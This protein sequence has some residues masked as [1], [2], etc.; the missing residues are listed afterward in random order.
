MPSRTYQLP[1]KNPLLSYWQDQES[2]AFTL[3]TI[4]IDTYGTEGLSWAPETIEMEIETDFGAD[5]PYDNYEKLLTAIQLLTDNSFFVSPTDFCRACVVLS[6]HSVGNQ[7]DL[8]DAAEVAWGVTEAML[9]S[10]PDKDQNKIF[11]DEIT[12]L[13]GHILDEEGIINPP[14]VLRIATREQNLAD[15][16]NYEFSDDPE[17]FS[18]IIKFEADKTDAINYTVRRKMRALLGQLRSLPISL[19]NKTEQIA[20]KMLERLSG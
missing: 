5:L 18:L 7:F 15:R 13:I 6:G 16:V 1:G 14:D 17:M 11:R 19:R 8:P 20:T 10:P 12:A 3:L 9:I 4:F 2:F